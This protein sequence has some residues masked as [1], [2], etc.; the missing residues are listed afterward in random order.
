MAADD[1]AE[2]KDSSKSSFKNI[3]ALG[4]V[5]FFT[6]VST[7]MVLSLLPVFI[8]NLPSSGSAALGII[9]GIAES[10]SY[11]MRVVSGIFS[12]KLR[13]RKVIILLGYGISNIV[14]P[15][16]A[17]VNNIFEAMAIRVADRIGKGIRTAPRDALLSESVD[18]NRRGI[19]FGLH[20]TL[21]Q[22][23][24]ILGPLAASFLMYVT[25]LTIRGIFWLSFIPGI[26]ALLTLLFF[27]QERAAMGQCGFKMLT[28]IQEA[29]KEDLLILLL[30]VGV[31]SLGAFN[32]SFVLLNASEA[33]FDYRAIPVFY[34]LINLSHTIIAIPSGVLSDRI[35]KESVL[36]MGYGAFLAA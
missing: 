22:T 27:V 7:E 11:G 17:V 15:F 9:E 8:V 16:F 28:G 36:V 31:F 13:R 19:A 30:I 14:K 34:A 6:D 18:E 21:D 25:G 26:A 35:G 1:K 3:F 20:R 24:A 10:L 23:G 32:Y 2:S 5:S 33:G 29:L 12:D 4:F